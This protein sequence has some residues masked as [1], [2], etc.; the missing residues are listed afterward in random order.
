MAT[1]K[2]VTNQLLDELARTGQLTS[3]AATY[4][5]QSIKHYQNKTFWFNEKTIEFSTTASG[6]YINLTSDFA[7]E[8]GL[9]IRINTN[10]YPLNRK[11]MQ[12]MDELYISAGNY[13]GYPQ[14]YAI[15]NRQVR[16]GP[17]PNGGYPL[18]MH[19]KRR[20]E[21][22]SATSATNVMIENADDLVI[23]RAGKLM[24]GLVLQDTQRAQIFSVAEQEALRSHESDTTQ[25]QMTGYT[26][27]RR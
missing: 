8:Y 4:I 5:N 6:E 1:L 13:T 17:V 9:N 16:L 22:L 10:N 20:A 2:T 21:Q 25:Y 14:D 23:A 19:Y 12:E 11:T 24:C 3:Q 7:N 18:I 26:K 15:F 27:R